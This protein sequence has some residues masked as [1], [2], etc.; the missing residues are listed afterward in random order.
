MPALPG[1]PTG[2][3]RK[4]WGCERYCPA[5][6]VGARQMVGAMHGRA[7]AHAPLGR[8]DAGAPSGTRRWTPEGMGQRT[9]LPRRPCRGSAN[10][11]GRC[12]AGRRRTRRWAGRMP[13]FPAG[14]AGARRKAWGSERYCPAGPVGARQTVGAE[15]GRAQAHAPLGRQDAGAPSGTRR[16]TPKGMG[17][18]TLLPRGPC[19]GS[20][21]GWG[22]ARPGAGARAAG[23]AGCRRSQG[24]PHA[25][26]IGQSSRGARAY[27]SLP[28]SSRFRAG[29]AISFRDEENNPGLG[30]CRRLFERVGFGLPCSDRWVGVGSRSGAGAA[31]SAGARQARSVE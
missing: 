15:H 22:D 18:R 16:C 30:G 9:L 14:P 21:N 10:G 24:R 20:A 2:G 29:L 1:G 5:G 31:D 28:L 3:R 4:A 7:Q 12:T 11:W 17:Q 27:R 26:A 13:A 25:A 6:P 8:Q 19:R 23:P